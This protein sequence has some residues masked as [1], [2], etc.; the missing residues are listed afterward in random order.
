[1]LQSRRPTATRSLLQER[2]STYEFKAQ[3]WAPRTHINSSSS[4]LALGTIVISSSPARKA[5][6][7]AE[8]MPPQVVVEDRAIGQGQAKRQCNG[9]L[10]CVRGAA[11]ARCGAAPQGC[12]DPKKQRNSNALR[13]IVAA[14]NCFRRRGGRAG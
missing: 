12:R 13:S 5:I 10:G 1:M 8:P 7:A 11:G 9:G 4:I 6:S 14:S 2:P 3:S